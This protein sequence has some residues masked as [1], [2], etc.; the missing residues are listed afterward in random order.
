MTIIAGRLGEFYSFTNVDPGPPIV[1]SNV[2]AGATAAPAYNN[3]LTA[4]VAAL[5]G[6]LEVCGSLVDVSISGNVDELETTV[7]NDDTATPGAP[8]AGSGPTHGT[9]RNVH[10]K[11]PR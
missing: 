3:P 1:Y 5:T 7:H 10:S 11:L 6:D 2:D 9:A 8:L 4:A